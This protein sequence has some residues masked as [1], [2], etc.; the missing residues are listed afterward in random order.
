MKIHYRLAT[1]EDNQKLLEL[2]GSAGMPGKISLRIDR[3]PNFFELN[4]L[5]GKTNVYVAEDKNEIVGSICVSDQMVYTNGKKEPLYYISDFKVARTYRNRGIGL[6]LTNEVVK[7][8]ESKDADFAFLNVSKGNN[9]PFVFFSDR[10]HYPDFQNIGTFTT[11]EFM[12][13]KFNLSKSKFKIELAKASTEILDF[14][15]EYYEQYQLARVITYDNLNNTT[16][17]VVRNG[18]H[19]IGVMSIIDTTDFKQNVVLKMPLTLKFIVSLTNAFCNI[20]KLSKLPKE[21]ESIKML[22]IKY[23][24]V[25]TYDKSLITALISF[26]R[27]YAYDK[28]Y[29]FVSIGL[30]EN[31]ILIK[32]LPKLLRFTF[33][34]VGMLVSMKNSKEVLD[35]IK[36]GMPFRDYSII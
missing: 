13:S 9:R 23:L 27:Q 30:H 11:F 12:G 31:D 20:F 8:L 16:L 4:K 15:N 28:S 14:L 35:S 32:K 22:Y 10:A 3:H 7:Y 19:I 29:S 25:K 6:Q 5:R 21:N 2:T 36:K 24:A 34:S 17:Y 1:F 33:Y 26:A 18:D